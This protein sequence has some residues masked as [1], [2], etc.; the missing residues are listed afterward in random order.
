MSKISVVEIIPRARH[1]VNSF[2]DNLDSNITVLP[3]NVV[4]AVVAL[5]RLG[6]L[7]K[8]FHDKIERFGAPP[9]P[10]LSHGHLW[11]VQMRCLGDGHNPK[12]CGRWFMKVSVLYRVALAAD[13]DLE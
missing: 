13:I 4:E 9:P 5:T 6:E 10:L 2:I 12:N 8:D 3:D 1:L 7:Y 11:L